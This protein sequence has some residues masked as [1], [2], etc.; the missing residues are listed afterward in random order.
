MTAAQAAATPVSSSLQLSPQRSERVSGRR[1]LTGMPSWV[2]IPVFFFDMLTFLP[3]PH[4][5]CL[6]WLWR[7]TWGWQKES[8]FISIGAIAKGAGVSR[9]IA[10]EALSWFVAVRR[11]VV[12]PRSRGIR[13]TNLLRVV[14]DFD[15]CSVTGALRA[16]V[17][18]AAEQ[19][20][21]RSVRRKMAAART[22]SSAPDAR[23]LVRQAHSSTETSTNTTTDGGLRPPFQPF[24]VERTA[25]DIRADA[26]RQQEALREWEAKR[27]AVGA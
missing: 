24:P 6:L 25:A 13:R 22:S 7:K 21:A 1:V 4:W 10:A 16:L 19:R 27:Q 14:A 9:R 20:I 15:Q 26:Q 5:R 3:A 18:K 11:V 2:G 12:D 23:Q 8:D 17:K